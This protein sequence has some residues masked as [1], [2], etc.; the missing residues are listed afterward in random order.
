[1]IL[2][3][4]SISVSAGIWLYLIYRY[5][6]FE[7]EPIKCVLL[8]GA[9]GGIMSSIPAAFLNNAAASVLGIG[10]F[11]HNTSG[12]ESSGYRILLFSVFVGF[13]EELWKSFIAVMILK[14]LKQFNEP[15]DALIY[16]M[17]IALGFA[18]FENISYTVAGGFGALLIR[19]FTAVPLHA[20]LAS[21]WG[22]GISRAKYHNDKKYFRTLIPYVT[23]AALIHALYNYIQF[24][25]FNNPFSLIIALIF[26]FFIILYAAGKLKYFQK[27]SPFRRSGLCGQCGTLNSVF[28]RYCKN[29][30]SYIVTDYYS[31]CTSCG[32]RNRKG[33]SIC[34]NCGERIQEN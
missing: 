11:I 3:Y 16:S 9:I 33:L 15:I 29:C 30:G 18:A 34:R 21:I 24:I 25:S 10:G 13:N 7:P 20:G 23:A 26:V 5:D 1:M 2:T 12:A 31:L 28:A 4:L 8:V 22:S 6:R 27:E 32:A 19:S 17:S 14:R